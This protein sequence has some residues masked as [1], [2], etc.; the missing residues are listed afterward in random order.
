MLDDNRSVPILKTLARRHPSALVRRKAVWAVSEILEGDAV[1][2]LRERERSETS[3]RVKVAIRFALVKNGDRS[4]LRPFIEM[5][6]SRDYIVRASIGSFLADHVS[7]AGEDREQAARYVRK[8]L[9]AEQTRAAAEAL[10]R[11]LLRLHGN[12]RNQRLGRST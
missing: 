6:R 4:R 5:L 7:L 1:P 12:V 11:A 2:F 10:N 3:N 8:A 9:S